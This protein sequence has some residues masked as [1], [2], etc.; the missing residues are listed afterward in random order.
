[1]ALTSSVPGA[2][3]V[4]RAGADKSENPGSVILSR[5]NVHFRLR[6]PLARRARAR[7]GEGGMNATV[8]TT[9][10][11]RRLATLPDI[12]ARLSAIQSDESD[13]SAALAG[14]LSAHEPIAASL[15]SLKSLAPPLDALVADTRLFDQTVSFTARTAQDV[16][17]RV[18]SLD[19]EMRRVREAS[20]RV[21]QIIE[22]KVPLPPCASGIYR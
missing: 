12:L 22:L 11:P 18:Q 2:V 21:S 16:G 6:K 13:L 8:S 3:I 14:L 7:S 19:E 9:S 1:M 15:N 5:L 20:E 17:G 4:D 10:D